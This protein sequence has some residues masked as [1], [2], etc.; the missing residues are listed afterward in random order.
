V[1]MAYEASLAN[2]ETP[3][4]ALTFQAEKREPH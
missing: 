1:A 4:R 2:D 3:L